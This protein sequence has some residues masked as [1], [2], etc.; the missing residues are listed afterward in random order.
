MDAANKRM[1]EMF[2][3][4]SLAPPPTVSIRRGEVPHAQASDFVSIQKGVK[5]T[6]YM[7][8]DV[9]IVVS[10]IELSK[11]EPFTASYINFIRSLL[12]M[13]GD[14]FLAH[15]SAETVDAIQGLYLEE[16]SWEHNI[17]ID[18]DSDDLELDDGSVQTAIE[19]LYTTGHLESFVTDVANVYVETPPS[20][21]TRR[22]TSQELKKIHKEIESEFSGLYVQS[23]TRQLEYMEKGLQGI[24]LPARFE[25][26][27]STQ[28]WSAFFWVYPD[29]IIAKAD[30][31][32]FSKGKFKNLW[33]Q[34]HQNY[35][36][37]SKLSSGKAR[38]IHENWVKGL[39]GMTSKQGKR[40]AGRGSATEVLFMAFHRFDY[41]KR[42]I[43][44]NT[45]RKL[46]L[47]SLS[48][49]SRLLLSQVRRLLEHSMTEP[50][51]Q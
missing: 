36:R 27:Q 15:L 46:K 39:G 50:N 48:R 9:T 4:R 24:L 41:L 2:G 40:K 33:N 14:S 7:K 42:P 29:G 16:M 38:T 10:D 6:P 31:I 25:P 47:P 23:S 5:R 18:R 17:A 45:L 1:D 20:P 37:I 11:G 49:I 44:K 22:Q 30:V 32:T 12:A 51:P 21:M 26:P 28:N 43:S 3:T 8:K 13:R 35:L 34:H 19:D